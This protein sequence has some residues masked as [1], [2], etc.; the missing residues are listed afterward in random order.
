MQPTP[1]ELAPQLRA[2]LANA[3]SPTIEAAAFCGAGPQRTDGSLALTNHPCVLDPV[4]LAAALGLPPARLRIA[5][6]FEAVADAIPALRDEEAPMLAGGNGIPGTPHLV[7]GAGTGLGVAALL[8]DGTDWR[9]LP[10]EGGHVDLAPVS[11]A[12]CAVFARLRNTFGALSAETILSGPGLARLHTALHPHE[13]LQ[14]PEAISAAAKAGDYEALATLGARGGVWIAG[15]IVPGWGTAF[16]ASA[17]REGFLDK[18]AQRGWLAAIPI[19]VVRHP[20]P[21]LL[22]LARRASA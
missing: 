15:G 20:Q 22:G 19:R 4:S 10:G 11:D 7:L 12:E 17:F 13:A 5:N 2:Y 1:R 21:G 9:V 14:T 16:D 18:P 6:D 3:G 8:P